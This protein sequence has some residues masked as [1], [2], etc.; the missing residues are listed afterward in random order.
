MPSIRLNLIIAV[1]LLTTLSDLEANAQQ[2]RHVHTYTGSGFYLH[3]TLRLRP[4]AGKFSTAAASGRAGAIASSPHHVVASSPLQVAVNTFPST[5]EAENGAVA[6]KATGGTPPYLYSYD[7]YPYETIAYTEVFG[8]ASV[9]VTVMDATGATVTTTADVGNNLPQV[10]CVANVTQYPTGCAGTNGSVQVT[11]IGGVPPYTYSVDYVNWQTSGVFNN[12]PPGDYTFFIRDA[13]GCIGSMWS[14]IGGAGCNWSMGGSGSGFICPG[15]D[16]GY[17]DFSVEDKSQPVTYSLDGVN[18]QSDELFPNQPPGSYNLYMKEGG[19]L[20]I[21]RLYIWPKCFM[22]PSLT[23]TDATC[24]NSDGTIVANAVNGTPPYTYSIDGFNFQTSNTFTGLAPGYYTIYFRDGGSGWV[25]ALNPVVNSGCPLSVTLTSTNTSCGYHNGSIV[26]TGSGG[27]GPYIYSID[28]THFQSSPVFNNLAAGPYSVMIKDATGNFA[29]NGLIITD[30][31]GNN[32]IELLPSTTDA[33]CGSNNGTITVGVANGT[34]PY[35]Y[36]L[37]GISFQGSSG[38]TVASGNY[39]V[40]VKDANGNKTT[41][42]AVVG[43]VGG[44]QLS[45]APTTASCLNNDGGFVVSTMDG[46]AP[47]QFAADGQGFQNAGVFSGVG[48]GPH[49][50]LVKDANG[51]MVSSSVTVPLNNTLAVDAGSDV[52]ICR[53]GPGTVLTGATN[54]TQFSWSPA[55]GLDNAGLLHP[56]ASPSVTT[57]YTL[58]AGLGVCQG[59]AGVTVNVTPAPVADAGKDTAICYGQSVQLK[60]GGGSGYQWS[61]ASGLDDPAIADP[62]V[63]QPGHSMI[64]QLMVTDASGCRSLQPAKVTVTVIPTPA[65]YIGNDTSVLGGQPVPLNVD[66]LNN[67]GFTSY[68]W[69]PAEGL[70]DPSIRDP[71]ASVFESTTYTVVATTAGGCS[72]SANIFLKIYSAAGIFVPNAFTPNGDGHNDVLKAVPVGISQFRYFAVYARWGQRVYFTGDASQGWDGT[73]GGRQASAGTYVWMAAGVDYNGQLVER[74]G[75]VI[76][77]R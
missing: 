65:I 74:K 7:G 11:P 48:S 44:P 60:G 54:G 18:F 76:L 50:V 53:G 41:A 70:S 57:T 55:T 37:D 21:Y 19:N 59:T 68:A 67:S 45:I 14:P 38:F 12:L 26:A 66:D 73:V 51:C 4:S 9:Q 10:E 27:E 42:P 58:T 2:G 6:V 33:T 62:T 5:C 61:P 49:T 35:Q 47:F 32:C 13:N 8:P 31:P 64:Y 36:S 52:S 22:I 63:V 46:K 75:T 15:T 1:L 43:N 77:I 17:I 39:T 16:H 72:A 71:V 56:T 30:M 34:P 28:A 20:F 29:T 25:R 23:V 40:T 24:G 69:T 3:D